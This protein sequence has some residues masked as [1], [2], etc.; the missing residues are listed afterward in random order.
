[1]TLL[2]HASVVAGFQIFLQEQRYSIV[3]ESHMESMT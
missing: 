1:M 2:I 3:L